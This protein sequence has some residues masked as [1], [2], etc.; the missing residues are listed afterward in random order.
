M[1]CRYFMTTLL[2]KLKFYSVLKFNRTF[3]WSCENISQIIFDLF[4]LRTTLRKRVSL[5]ISFVCDRV[6]MCVYVC[7]PFLYRRLCLFK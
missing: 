7:P 6:S 2:N 1:K 4:I 3:C 5:H